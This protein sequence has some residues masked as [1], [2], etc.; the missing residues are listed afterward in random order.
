MHLEQSE[1]EIRGHGPVML[2]AGVGWAMYLQAGL[3]RTSDIPME[4]HRFGDLHRSGAS[5]RRLG[6]GLMPIPHL[7]Q[8]LIF[9]AHF[10]P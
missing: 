4:S 6:A 5:A 3:L 2:R 8:R 7:G 9:S 10:L 1:E